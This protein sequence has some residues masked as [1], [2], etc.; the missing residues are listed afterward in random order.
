MPMPPKNDPAHPSAALK[1]AD[2]ADLAL[3]AMRAAED[4]G[5]FCS[6][7]PQV[8]TVARASW[9]VAVAKMKYSIRLAYEWANG[10]EST[11]PP[12]A[13]GEAGRK[14]RDI[15]LPPELEHLRRRMLDDP[16][17]LPPQEP[18]LKGAARERQARAGSKL[19]TGSLRKSLAWKQ[20][21]ADTDAEGSEN[22]LRLDDIIVPW[23]GPS[24]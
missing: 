20:E 24:G 2:Q 22:T 12:G 13:G 11:R 15:T 4:V 3:A 1:G 23:N 18:P 19:F 21:P 14:R 6:R 9:A 5:G 10:A 16:D 8:C 17:E 7:Q